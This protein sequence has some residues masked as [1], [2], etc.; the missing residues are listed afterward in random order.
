M[1]YTYHSSRKGI[2]LIIPTKKGIEDGGMP[3][4]AIIPIG[5]LHAIPE[6]QNYVKQTPH[7]VYTA[8]HCD[9]ENI[10]TH[11]V[12]NSVVNRFG[13][14]L[15]DMQILSVKKDWCL[16]V[17]GPGWFKRVTITK[18]KDIEKYIKNYSWQHI[19]FVNSGNPYICKTEK[20]FEKI[21]RKY[22]LE[23]I[24]DGF[25]LAKEKK[26]KEVKNVHRACLEA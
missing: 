13:L 19:E 22:D 17:G 20:A 6:V 15:T 9:R 7:N 12:P 14:Y 21:Q 2:D 26:Y 24:K 10:L 8:K 16:D 25:W 4:G 11:I 1:S 18:I 5:Y 23:N 3:K